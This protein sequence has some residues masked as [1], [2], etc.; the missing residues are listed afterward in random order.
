[1]QALYKTYK[2]YWSDEALYKVFISNWGHLVIAHIVFIVVLG[3]T[4]LVLLDSI[5]LL[6]AP[7]M[8]AMVI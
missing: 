4:I 1:M 2:T 5:V 6:S 7:Y 3:G 8:I